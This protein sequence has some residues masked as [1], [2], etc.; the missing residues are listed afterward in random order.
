MR[1]LSLNANAIAAVLALGTVVAFAAMIVTQLLPLLE[2][3]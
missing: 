1:N 3:R 2:V